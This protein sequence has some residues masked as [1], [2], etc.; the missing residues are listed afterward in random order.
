MMKQNQHGFT[1]LEV[2]VS[3][4]IFSLIS[5]LIF[6]I[7]DRSFVFTAKGEARVLEIEQQYGLINLVRRQVQGAWFDQRQKKIQMSSET[8]NRFALITTSSLMYN[9]SV[10]VMAFYEFDP[11]ASILYY[12]E[13]KDFYNTGYSSMPPEVTEMIPLLHVD[14][15]F[16]LQAD[17][18]SDFVVL[19]YKEKKYVFHPF[20][21]KQS[22]EFDFEI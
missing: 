18:D 1:L 17:P 21:T 14:G 11:R 20:C 4:F 15:A 19:R 16:S 2:M 10:L 12:T 22:Q 13:R 9:S 5:M 8:E 3:I 6:S 7:L